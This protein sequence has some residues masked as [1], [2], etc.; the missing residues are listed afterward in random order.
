MRGVGGEFGND[1]V[2]VVVGVVHKDAAVGGIAGVEGDAEEALLVG[3]GAHAVGYVEKGIV[4]DLTV[5]HDQ[6]P[7]LLLNN[8]E[9]AAGVAGM[10]DENGAIETAGHDLNIDTQTVGRS[11]L[12][13]SRNFGGGSRCWRGFR[14]GLGCRRCDRRLSGRRG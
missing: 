5:L 13:R 2:A 14:R 11:G 4:A 3:L 12:R 8:E 10:A 6:N 9:P 7:A 1:G